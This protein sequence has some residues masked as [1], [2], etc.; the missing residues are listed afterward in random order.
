MPRRSFEVFRGDGVLMAAAPWEVA[1][2][3]G[4]RVELLPMKMPV[5]VGG[6]PAHVVMWLD[7]FAVRFPCTKE[8]RACH[9]VLQKGFLV[10]SGTLTIARFSVTFERGCE[11]IVTLAEGGCSTQIID[12]VFEALRQDYSRSPQS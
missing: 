9:L 4:R 3:T 6:E 10:A 5:I 2:V 7:R 11:G 8:E 1:S 12:E